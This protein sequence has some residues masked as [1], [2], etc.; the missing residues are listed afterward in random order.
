MDRTLCEGAS[1]AITILEQDHARL[2]KL[3]SDFG[4]FDQ[5][6]EQACRKAVDNVCA[7][8]EIHTALE[9]EVLFP[10]V[11]AVLGDHSLRRSVEIEH[12]SDQVVRRIASLASTEVR[13]DV[14][15]SALRKF[16]ITHME[17]EEKELFPQIERTSLD[18]VR[19]GRCLCAR[20]VELEGAQRSMRGG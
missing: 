2:R 14:T 17:H 4:R 13:F 18:L 7:E 3:M 9:D 19:I 8:I 10:A 15:F 12:R 5:G 16:M 1:D 11:L 6:D 20:R